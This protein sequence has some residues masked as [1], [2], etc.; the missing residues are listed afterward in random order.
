MG[1]QKVDSAPVSESRRKEPDD[2]DIHALLNAERLLD[3]VFAGALEL[4]YWRH[5]LG[6]ADDVLFS[7]DRPRLAHQSLLALRSF[8]PDI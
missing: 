2:I 8:F 3:R 1:F 6:S 4:R 5:M 7:L